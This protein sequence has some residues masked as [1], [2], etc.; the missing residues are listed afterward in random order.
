[1]VSMVGG[2]ETA[3]DKCSRLQKTGKRCTWEAS[4]SSIKSKR[5][6][7]GHLLNDEGVCGCGS[8]GEHGGENVGIGDLSLGECQCKSLV[9]LLP[10]DVPPDSAAVHSKDVAIE[11]P[12]TGDFIISELVASRKC[13][14]I[15][16]MNIA[17][18]NKKTCLTKVHVQ[19]FFNIEYLSTAG[20]SMIYDNHS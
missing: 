10:K 18:E 13:P 20:P 9:D 11:N 4:L 8:S 17:D 3:D 15:M 12:A 6:K 19:L 5:V 14:K 7:G 1:M 2:S 16:F